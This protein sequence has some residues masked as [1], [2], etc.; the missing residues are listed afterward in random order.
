MSVYYI[1][2]NNGFLKQYYVKQAPMTDTDQSNAA[3][4]SAMLRNAKIFSSIEEAKTVIRMNAIEQCLVI[5]QNG[6]SEEI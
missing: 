2:T 3:I 4:F 5:N 1:V 6:E